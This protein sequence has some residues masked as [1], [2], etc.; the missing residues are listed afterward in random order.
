[1]PANSPEQTN[2]MLVDAFHSGDL[3][4]AVAL[5]E[6][7]ATLFAE[8]GHP[9]TGTAAIREALGGF[10]AMKP[11]MKIETVVSATSGDICLTQNKWTMKA[12]GPDGSPVDMAGQSA[13]VVRRQ[14]DGSWKFVIDNPWGVG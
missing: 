12:I 13:E 5:Y 10:I 3:E 14:A 7:D 8:P 6:A 9:A 1:M 2:Q 11:T 4:A